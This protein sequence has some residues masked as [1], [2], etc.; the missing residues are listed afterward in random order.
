[1]GAV[2]AGV[3][4]LPGRSETPVSSMAMHAQAIALALADAG[5]P[6][7]TVDGL[8]TA[9]SRPYIPQHVDLLPRL[10]SML[11]TSDIEVLLAGPEDLVESIGDGL[12]DVKAGWIPLE[13]ALPTCDLMVHHG[14]GGT[15]M[16][17]LRV[18]V[19]QLMLPRSNYQIGSTRPVA[20]F[21]AGLMLTPGEDTLEEIEKS[22]LELLSNPS[23]A[24]R[25]GQLSAEIATLPSPAEVVGTLENLVT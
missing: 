3:G 25:A 6:M 23:Y 1:M 15:T 16:G 24:E 12:G 7:S 14:G 20:E 22:C 17:A 9:G 19:P 2:I 11:S 21:G 4:E 8:V 18:G 10:T 5:I 13:V